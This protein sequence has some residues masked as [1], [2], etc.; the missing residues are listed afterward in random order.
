MGMNAQEKSRILDFGSRIDSIHNRRST[1]RNPAGLLAND[2]AVAGLIFAVTRLVALAGAYSGVSRLVQA[3]PA[4][5]KGWLAELALMWDSAWYVT[6]AQQGYTWHPGASG[7][8]NVAFAPF[9][10]FLLRVVSTFLGWVTFGWDWGQRT[11]GTLIAAGLLVSNISFFVAL[12]LLIRLLA[13]RLGR[14]GA[15]LVA[16]ALASLPLSFFF[17]ALYTEG[18]FLMLA[19]SSL[20]IARSEWRMKWP[21]AALVGM[22][23]CLLKFAGVLILPVLAVEYLSQRGWHLRRVRADVLWLGIVPLGLVLYMGFLWLRFGNPFAFMDSEYKGWNHQASFFL[24]T[25]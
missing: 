5:N 14:G 21:A 2:W 11:Y 18:P 8:T 23:A 9:Y 20:L 25:Y 4:R 12:V 1:I 17:S 16:L 10:P 19:L 6:I 24:G 13:P 22:L 3:E 15:A 7:G